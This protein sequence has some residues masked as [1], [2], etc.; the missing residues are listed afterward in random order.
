MQV[1]YTPYHAHMIAQ[2]VDY[3]YNGVRD[4]IE[5]H[6]TKKFPASQHE[7]ALRY[8]KVIQMKMESNKADEIKIKEISN[9]SSSILSCIFESIPNPVVFSEEIISVTT[10]TKKRLLAYLEFSKA[11]NGKVLS[12]I[13]CE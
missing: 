7:L 10:N 9:E 3:N 13:P 6:I 12:I 5:K 8:A 2:N 11:L 1:Q 4:D